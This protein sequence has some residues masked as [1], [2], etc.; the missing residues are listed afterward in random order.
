MQPFK[1]GPDYIDPTYHSLAAG[2]PCRN[3]DTWMLPP[4]RVRSLFTRAAHDADVAI[5]EGVM[6]LY[7]GA[8]YDDESGSTAE[9]AKLLDAP[10][11]VVLDASR[12]ARSAGAVALGYQRFDEQVPLAGFIVNRVAGRRTRPRSCVGRCQ[13]HRDSRSSAGCRAT[14]DCASPNGTSA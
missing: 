10:V 8:D 12:M 6:G 11:I 13:S 14:R 9:V 7:D 5:I 2:R 4:E 3:L 1:V